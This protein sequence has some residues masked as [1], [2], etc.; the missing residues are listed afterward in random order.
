MGPFNFLGVP[1]YLYRGA[2]CIFLPQNPDIASPLS[3]Y[4]YLALWKNRICFTNLQNLVLTPG[5][6][7]YRPY[8]TTPQVEGEGATG[9]V[10]KVLYNWLKNPFLP[11]CSIFRR[12]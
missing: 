2:Y 1:S 10:Y 12:D 3:I 6:G 11:I 5:A 8:P 7:G 9:G 4:V